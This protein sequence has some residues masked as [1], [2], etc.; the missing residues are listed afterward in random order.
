M[1]NII[2]KL[3]WGIATIFIVS[4]SLYFTFKLKFIQI[5]FNKMFKYL[6]EKNTTKGISP[7][8]SLMLS[9]AGRLGVGSIAGVALAIS[10]GGPGSLFWLLVVSFFTTTLSFSETILGIK[11]REKDENGYR[12]GPSEYIAKGLG[13]KK[14]GNTYSLIILFS[15]VFGFIG[16][17]ANTITKAVT[18][19]YNV[20]PYLI[21][22]IIA[23]F[24]I[25]II[26]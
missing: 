23:I 8:K 26:Y 1:I 2:N 24:T 6:F 22:A 25:I 10:T 4:S 3:L 9:L 19:S 21:G 5:R 11:Y 14:L 15:Y 17:Q 13:K 12:G 20:M 7:F 16:I 18:T